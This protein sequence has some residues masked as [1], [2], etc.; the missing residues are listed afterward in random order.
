MSRADGHL[1]SSICKRSV[2]IGGHKT[3]VTLEDVFWQGLRDIALARNV[4][5]SALLDEINGSR[6]CNNLSSHIRMFV[7]EY[8]RAQTAQA[9][10]TLRAAIVSPA[11]SSLDPG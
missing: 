9:A 11:S 2:T 6:A 10:D 7:L 8:F 4:A 3:S 1:R 5:V